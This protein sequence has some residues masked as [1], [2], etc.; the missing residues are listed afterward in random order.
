MECFK[1]HDYGHAQ[2]DCPWN[3]PAQTKT[4]HKE[5]IAAIVALWVNDVIS[6]LEKRRAIAAENQ[7]Y[8]G[9]SCPAHLLKVT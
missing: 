6:M 7:L 8:Y 1:C 4:E 3:T 9:G 2:R 5:R